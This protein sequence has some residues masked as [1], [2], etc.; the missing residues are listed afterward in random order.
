MGKGMLGAGH[1][2]LSFEQL[3][4]QTILATVLSVDRTGPGQAS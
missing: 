3:A 1:V 4:K 2:A